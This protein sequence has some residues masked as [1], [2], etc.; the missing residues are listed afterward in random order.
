MANILEFL[1]YK[2]TAYQIPLQSYPLYQNYLGWMI[3]W[4]INFMD[5]GLP[6]TIQSIGIVFRICKTL[7]FIIIWQVHQWFQDIF[8]NDPSFGVKRSD[9]GEFASHE[10]DYCFWMIHY[11]WK[12]SSTL[13][14]LPVLQV[15][16]VL[17]EKLRY[18]RKFWYMQEPAE[19]DFCCHHQPD[20]NQ[21]RAGEEEH[22]GHQHR[23]HVHQGRHCL[24]WKGFAR[25]R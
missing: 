20:L 16:Q 22:A 10:C 18:M 19:G 11:R 8:F 23:L 2:N 12:L 3:N 9:F 7:L 21:H 4:L 17:Q 13:S 1:W 15:L 6:W 25:T 14:L 5:R 24:S